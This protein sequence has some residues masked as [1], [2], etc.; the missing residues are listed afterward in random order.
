MENIFKS[1]I[2][3]DWT[4]LSF[5]NENTL[6]KTM[7]T[8]KKKRIIFISYFIFEFFDEYYFKNKSF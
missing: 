7:N 4:I 5:S 8:F 3:F 2:V 6:K 1:F